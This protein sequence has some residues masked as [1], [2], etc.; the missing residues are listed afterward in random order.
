MIFMR[1][2]ISLV[3]ELIGTERIVL[4]RESPRRLFHQFEVL[5]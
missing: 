1:M 2:H 3:S 4:N 5:A